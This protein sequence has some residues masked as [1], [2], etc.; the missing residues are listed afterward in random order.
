GWAYQTK[1]LAHKA[2]GQMREAEAALREAIKAKH[3]MSPRY[4][5]TMRFTMGSDTFLSEAHCELGALMQAQQRLEEAAD[6]YRK[7]IKK[8]GK[9]ARAHSQLGGVYLQ[10]EEPREA[11]KPLRHALALKEDLSGA[12]FDLG[13][14]FQKLGKLEDA[15]D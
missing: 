9:F 8:D 15:A 11:I 6:E 3:G 5:L 2:L 12:H 1:G 14:A 4:W 7:A 10:Q 13:R